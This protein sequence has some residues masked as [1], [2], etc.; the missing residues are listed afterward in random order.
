[1]VSLH[2]LEGLGLYIC[3][4]KRAG[5]LARIQN[6]TAIKRADPKRGGEEKRRTEPSTL[7]LKRN[8]MP[9]R[10]HQPKGMTLDYIRLFSE[11]EGGL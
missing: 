5:T 4:F 10:R 11:L 3:P 1:M 2:G 8:L 9:E 6:S 7:H